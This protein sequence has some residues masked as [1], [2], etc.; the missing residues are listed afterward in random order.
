MKSA[1]CGTEDLSGEK[2]LCHTNYRTWTAFF[3]RHTV[4]VI[5]HAALQ[6]KPLP[7]KMHEYISSE[8]VQGQDI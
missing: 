3:G 1:I 2:F 7:Q 5:S 6:E 8:K 4:L